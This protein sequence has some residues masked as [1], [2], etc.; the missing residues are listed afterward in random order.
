MDNQ[1]T[2]KERATLIAAA[3]RVLDKI[4][5]GD[6]D[7]APADMTYKDMCR[8]LKLSQR[9]LVLLA[10]LSD[11]LEES[12]SER[13]DLVLEVARLDKEVDD[14]EQR[15]ESVEEEASGAVERADP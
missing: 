4:E 3:R 9:T 10:Q 7:C 15:L 8:V 6:D 12:E 13:K 5:I 11:A 2:A 1:E 14:L